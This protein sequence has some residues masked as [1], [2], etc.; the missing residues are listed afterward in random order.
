MSF[1]YRVNVFGYFIHDELDKES[2]HACSGNYGLLDQI[3]ALRWVKENISA[4]GGNPDQITIMG[5]SAGA[6]SVYDLLCSPLSRDLISGAIMESGGGPVTGDGSSDPEAL[7]QY[8]DRF[9]RYLGCRTVDE[10]RAIP[11]QDLLGYYRD[12]QK[13]DKEGCLMLH[14]IPD[15]YSLPCATRD[16]FRLAEYADVPMLLGTTAD[17]DSNFDPRI[18]EMRDGFLG[19]SLALCEQQARLNREPTYLYHITNVPPGE[20]NR[21]AYHSGEHFYVFQ[22]LL[23]SNRPFVGI[24]YDLSNDMCDYWCNFIRE[25][26]P[27]SD[28]LPHWASYSV[29]SKQAMQFNRLLPREMID[30]PEYDGVPLKI[31]QD[32]LGL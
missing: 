19:G 16:L 21:G 27:N 12:F 23:A 5:Q 7:R 20:P 22:T 25:G 18:T 28:S 9:L 14:P 17:E 8:C 15:G 6:M 32:A 11:A 26:D 13:V 10:A 3:A 1:N 4:F 2:E 24:D 31:A 29:T 30:L